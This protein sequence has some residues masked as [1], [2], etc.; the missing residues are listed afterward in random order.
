MSQ[1]DLILVCWWIVIG[2]VSGISCALV[3][4]Y[5]VLRRMSL[6]GDA[7]SHAVLPGIVLAFLLTG[8]LNSIAIIIGAMVF[9]VLTAF[10][11]Q[12]IHQVG[13][14]PEDASMGVV[15]TALF[16][17]G[18]ILINRFVR[19]ADLDTHC[20]LYGSIEY[21]PEKA[22]IILG[23]AVPEAILTM[24]PVLLATV[25]IIVLLWK[26]LKI[27][28]FDPALA[29]AMG[30]NAT[31]LHY[32]LMAMVAGVTV[33]AFEAVGAI[34]PVAMLIVPA[35]TAQ[36]LTD[37]LAR[38][39]LCAAAVAVFSAV[40][41]AWSGW[42]LDTSVAGMIAVGAGLAFFLAVLFAPQHG[43]LSKLLRTFRL[44]LR[45]QKEDILAGLY[46]RKE[47]NQPS[48][49]ASAILNAQHGWGR[50]LAL[51]RLRQQGLVRRLPDGD[52]VLTDSGLLQAQSIVR[53]H[54]LWEAYLEKNVP[55]PLDHLHEPAER[56]E[57]YIG[58]V[59]QSELAAQ[60]GQPEIDPHGKSI[61][62]GMDDK[63]TR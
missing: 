53:A 33:T 18:V 59:L 61:P 51:A 50:R 44:G 8:R 46:R 39:L 54:R 14:V 36:L 1:A 3:G 22:E 13:K 23:F 29:T 10:L 15:F 24:L 6:L 35:A 45:I 38:M 28:A 5:L 7:I 16:A 60:L 30:L 41:G 12:T 32:L 27:A 9:G 62:P 26:E 57:H 34:L 56:M 2:S 20:V 43:I 48:A 47:A 63:V 17:A 19:H 55:L 11:T 21:A 25:A 58:P 37:R 52:I 4:C 42:L 31:L 40:F 49:S